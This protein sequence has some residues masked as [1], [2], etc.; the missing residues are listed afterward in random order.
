MNT[1]IWLAFA[2]GLALAATRLA[3]APALT[4]LEIREAYHDSYRYEKA[5]AYDDARK[6]LLPVLSAYPQGYTANL[7]LGW[8]YYLS[9]NYATAKTYYQTAIRVAPAS[10]EAKLGYLLPVLAQERFEEAETV[11]RQ[12]TR[13]DPSNYYGNLRLAFALRH[14]KKFDLA[15]EILNRMLA[16]YPTDVAFLTELGLVKLGQAKPEV[17][18]RIFADIL[19]LDPENVTAKEQLSARP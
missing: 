9:G 12:I 5:Q 16:L 4:E 2:L 17:A 1:A 15:E 8:L 19:T 18:R 3:G 7:R 14:Q 13:V 11:A 6:A 10:L